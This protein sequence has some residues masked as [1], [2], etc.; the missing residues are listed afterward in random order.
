MRGLDDGLN[1]LLHVRDD[2][3]RQNQQ[4]LTTTKTM[5]V[6]KIMNALQSGEQ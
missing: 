3:I 4:H 1:G 5:N 6:S 2:S